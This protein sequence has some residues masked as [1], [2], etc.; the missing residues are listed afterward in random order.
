MNPLDH[1]IWQAVLAEAAHAADAIP[2]GD[3]W[4]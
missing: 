3:H 2:T 1:Y 4:S